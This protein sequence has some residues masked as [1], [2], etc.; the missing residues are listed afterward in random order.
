MN[1]KQEAK[2]KSAI[3]SAEA[4]IMAQ[5]AQSAIIQA[6][7][8]IL[9]NFTLRLIRDW[10]DARDAAGIGGYNEASLP[11]RIRELREPR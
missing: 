8:P 7:S 9:A 4:S 10:W 11:D 2:V 6:T 5:L 3:S 1:M